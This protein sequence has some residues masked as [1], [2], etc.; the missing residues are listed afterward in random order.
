[1]V[2]SL[3][4]RIHKLLLEY[5]DSLK[6]ADILLKDWDEGKLAWVEQEAVGHFLIQSGYS[7]AF[8]QQVTKNFKNGQKIP[9]ASFVQALGLYKIK[10]TKEDFDQIFVGAGEE[11]SLRDLVRCTLFDSEDNR[12]LKIRSS[13]ENNTILRKEKKPVISEVTSGQPTKKIIPFVELAS[14]EESMALAKEDSIHFT[15]EKTNS[16]ISRFQLRGE[17]SEELKKYAKELFETALKD[18]PGQESDAAVA[19]AMMGAWS[20]ALEILRKQKS[21]LQRHFLELEFLLQAGKNVEVLALS[22]KLLSESPNVQQKS[23]ILYR[24]SQA[25]I[26]LKKPNDAFSILKNLIAENPD[27]LAAQ[28]LMSQLRSEAE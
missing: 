17:D 22:E 12:F 19:L 26:N 27:H 14:D 25:L 8:F 21:S 13:L 3:E 24:Q 5:N 2:Q 20:E 16:L 28:T 18:A 23:Y 4:L 10:L 15:P 7:R 11:Q 1:M 9:W 6:V